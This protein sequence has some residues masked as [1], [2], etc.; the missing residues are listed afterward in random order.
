M[1]KSQSPWRFHDTSSF[2]S[3]VRKEVPGISVEAVA[4][5]CRRPLPHSMRNAYSHRVMLGVA[6][7]AE[8]L[9]LVD[10]AVAGVHA[11]KFKPVSQV[12]HPGKKSRSFRRPWCLSSE[13]C[14]GT[15][16]RFGHANFCSDP[17]GTPHRR[18]RGRPSRYR[19]SSRCGNIWGLALLQLFVLPLHVRWLGLQT[20][21]ARLPRSD[22]CVAAAWRS[23][24]LASTLDN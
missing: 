12:I 6:A 24:T 19:L 13:L 15:P 3:L 14:L 8:F 10:V 1:L 18:N 7:E 2:L 5:P 17:V 9:R 22:L 21:L 4:Y 11:A 20:V 16:R 23:G